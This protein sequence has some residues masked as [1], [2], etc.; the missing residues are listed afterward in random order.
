VH[1][2]EEMLIDAARQYVDTPRLGLIGRMH[3]GGWYVRTTDLF[4]MPR[5]AK[6]PR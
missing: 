1:L 5:P 3:G 6:P 2:A 4:E